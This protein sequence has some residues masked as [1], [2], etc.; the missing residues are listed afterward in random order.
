MTYRTLIFFNHILTS[1]LIMQVNAKNNDFFY[2]KKS[3]HTESDILI[4]LCTS[5]TFETLNMLQ[6]KLNKKIFIEIYCIKIFP[7]QFFFSVSLSHFLLAGIIFKLSF[8]FLTLNEIDINNIYRWIYEFYV[9][10]F[11]VFAVKFIFI[12]MGVFIYIL[13]CN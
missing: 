1:I 10:C 3:S 13:K 9:T 6:L 5:G 8:S 4:A 11:L 12:R 7:E 2:K